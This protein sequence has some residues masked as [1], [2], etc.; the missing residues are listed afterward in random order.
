MSTKQTTD[1]DGIGARVRSNDSCYVIE[2]TG[3]R[4]AG[5]RLPHTLHDRGETGRVG[6]R[7]LQTKYSHHRHACHTYHVTYMLV[8]LITSLTCLLRSYCIIT[9]NSY[10]IQTNVAVLG[11]NALNTTFSCVLEVL[12]RCTRIVRIHRYDITLI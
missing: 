2:G 8:T 3:R 10:D 11:P 7:H 5:T 1:E 9:T 6:Q 4:A 12:L